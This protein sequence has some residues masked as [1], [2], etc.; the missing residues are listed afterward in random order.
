MPDAP[1]AMGST[2]TVQARQ[3][4]NLA[5]VQEVQDVAG[6]T[7]GITTWT[8]TSAGSSNVLPSAQDRVSL[9]V[10]SRATY[11]VWLRFDTTIPTLAAHSWYL[12]PGDR[13]EVPYRFC[14]FPISLAAATDGGT[15]LLTAGTDA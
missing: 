13:W 12:S 6:K 9:I 7:Q 4:A 1:V 10:V 2:N 15:V 14:R 8:A 3:K 5:F 11:E